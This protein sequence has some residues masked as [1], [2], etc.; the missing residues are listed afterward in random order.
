MNAND[1]LR[2]RR[3]ALKNP[4][5]WVELDFQMVSDSLEVEINHNMSPTV[6]R[7]VIEGRFNEMSQ[8]D[9]C[10]IPEDVIEYLANLN[11]LGKFSI[12]Y[13]LKSN[14]VTLYPFKLVK[15]DKTTVSLSP[16]G[17]TFSRF[18]E[19]VDQNLGLNTYCEEQGAKISFHSDK[20]VIQCSLF[21]P[22]PEKQLSQIIRSFDV[23]ANK[24]PT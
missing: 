11:T 24:I 2:H 17:T 20:V 6:V 19:L 3:S 7:M 23:Y 21:Y 16:I 5:A 22:W 8:A 14:S 18:E 15:E 13:S 10:K 1:L 4:K 12:Q 9:Y